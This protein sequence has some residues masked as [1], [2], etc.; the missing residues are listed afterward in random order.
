MRVVRELKD[1]EDKGCTNL[2]GTDSDRRTLVDSEVELEAY[3]G[4]F[5]EQNCTM[6]M[7]VRLNGKFRFFDH[8]ASVCDKL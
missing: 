7:C 3:A 1:H 5:H 6:Q 4:G 2:F 8:F